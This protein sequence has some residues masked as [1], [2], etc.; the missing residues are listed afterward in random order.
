MQ[1][2]NDQKRE[3]AD[4]AE[5]KN[6]V[7]DRLQNETQSAGEALQEARDE[8]ARRAVDYASEAQDAYPKEPRKRSAISDR[9]WR[10]SAARCAPQAI[11]WPRRSKARPRNSC[12]MPP[13]DWKAFRPR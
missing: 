2:E 9:A 7:S 4:F 6:E 8:I 11:I 12:W 5:A 3:A 1:R 10:H 13:A